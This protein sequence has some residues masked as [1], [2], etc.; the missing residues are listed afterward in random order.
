MR[1]AVRA[2]LAC[3]PAANISQLAEEG[4]EASF[5]DQHTC[6]APQFAVSSA[7]YGWLTRSLFAGRGRLAGPGRIEYEIYRIAG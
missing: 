6:V 5:T 4:R 2:S 3:S 7:G 1:S